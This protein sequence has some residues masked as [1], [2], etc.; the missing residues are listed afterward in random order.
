VKKLYKVKLELNAKQRE[1]F[2]SILDM[3]IMDY[4]AILYET[5]RDGE[6]DI[7]MEQ[8]RTGYKILVGVGAQLGAPE[9]WL[10]DWTAEIR[11]ATC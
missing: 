11:G 6:C 5:V 10:E 4:A 3:V 1:A 9:K 8:F 7:S 2:L